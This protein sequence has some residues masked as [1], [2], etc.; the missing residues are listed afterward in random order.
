MINNA[1][2]CASDKCYLYKGKG[3]RLQVKNL[4]GLS[5]FPLIVKISLA[6]TRNW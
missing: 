3:N 4:E 2:T 5:L 1:F 6:L